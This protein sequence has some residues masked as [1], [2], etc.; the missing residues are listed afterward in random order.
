MNN[1]TISFGPDILDCGDF[2]CRFCGGVWG[3]IESFSAGGMCWDCVDKENSKKIMEEI[4][5][6]HKES[7][8]FARVLDG[9]EI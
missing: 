4:A 6:C 5:L 3:N 7:V 8:H 1:F 9:E 2:G